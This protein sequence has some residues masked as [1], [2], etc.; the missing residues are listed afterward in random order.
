MYMILKFCLIY[1]V[2]FPAA[3]ILSAALWKIYYHDD[4]TEKED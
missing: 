3:G 2:I 1:L 4:S